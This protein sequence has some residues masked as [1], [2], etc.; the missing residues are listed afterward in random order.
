MKRIYFFSTLVLVWLAGSKVMAQDFSNKGKDFWVAYGYHEV[1]V[2]G[3]NVQQMVLYFATEAVTTVTVSIPGLGYSQTYTNIP[4]NTVLTSNPIPK[5]G[6]QDARLLTESIAPENK[7]IHIVADHPIVAY[8]HIYNAN[9]SGATI[10]FPT[11]TLG[12]EYFSVNY[13]N[14]SNTPN[15]NCWFYVVACD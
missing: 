10:L 13:K 3:G 9:V 14:V 11:N 2:D 8:A 15:A 5:S 6:V 4:A 12:R 7:G 1:M